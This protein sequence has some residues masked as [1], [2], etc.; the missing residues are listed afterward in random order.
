MPDSPGNIDAMTDGMRFVELEY[1]GIM[2]AQFSFPRRL[3]NVP[4]LAFSLYAPGRKDILDMPVTVHVD[5]YGME[6]YI[7][8]YECAPFEETGYLTVCT[9]QRGEGCFGRSIH[10][11]PK[12][13]LIVL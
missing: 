13:S 11:L 1:D 9:N 7:E 6:G 10:G 3:T 8:T 12:A 2:L 5:G 4:Y